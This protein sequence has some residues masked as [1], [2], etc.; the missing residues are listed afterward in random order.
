MEIITKYCSEECCLKCFNLQCCR[1]QKQKCSFYK[2][3]I[4]GTI[5]LC[6]YPLALRCLFGALSDPYN[7]KISFLPQ[8]WW[9]TVME[10]SY[11]STISPP[12]PQQCKPSYSTASWSKRKEIYLKT[13]FALINGFISFFLF[14]LLQFNSHQTLICLLV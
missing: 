14:I 1:H 6:H 2:T 8:P 5:L 13:P 10:V 4:I 3:H 7:C 12:F 9:P 11:I